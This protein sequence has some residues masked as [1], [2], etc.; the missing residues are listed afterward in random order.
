MNNVVKYVNSTMQYSGGVGIRTSLLKRFK[1]INDHDKKEIFG[2]SKEG[3]LFTAFRKNE[4]N[5]E[6][7]E[8]LLDWYENDYICPFW[9]GCILKDVNNQE[10]IVTC[11]YTDNSI[12]L[13]SR[14]DEI[15]RTTIGSL[16][17]SYVKI[18][19]LEVIV[20]PDVTIEDLLK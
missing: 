20:E 10:W 18:G 8:S 6:D 2:F 14:E 9:T 13:I 12:D 4:I 5:E 1:N 15:Q 17:S 11:V 3:E 16:G 19:S 7:L